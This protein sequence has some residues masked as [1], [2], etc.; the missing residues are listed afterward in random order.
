MKGKLNKQD[1]IFFVLVFVFLFYIQIASGFSII[2]DN[3]SVGSSS[4]GILGGQSENL[5]YSLRYSSLYSQLVGEAFNSN[6]T[7]KSGFL[8][9]VS[10]NVTTQNITNNV[11]V[12]SKQPSVTQSVSSGSSGI[13]ATTCNYEWVCSDWYPVPCPKEEIQKRVC[14]NRGTCNGSEGMP[15]LNRSCVSSNLPLN[16]P[17]F[18]IFISTLPPYKS[19]LSGDEVKFNIKLINKRDTPSLDVTF[20]YWIV[21]KNNKL[22]IERQ[23]TRAIKHDDEFNIGFAL[24]RNLEPGLYKT[25]V[26]IKY[27]SNKTALAQ[28]SFEVINGKYGFLTKIILFVLLIILVLSLM[29]R[30]FIKIV[31]KRRRYKS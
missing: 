24:P 18:D 23:D 9:V 27:D 15:E 3:Y 17:L 14:V 28:D 2:S 22:I 11:T 1:F 25:F 4:Q 29:M 10:I 16:K 6:Y 7:A 12:P 19:I 21:G 26:E 20:R 30:I 31:G 8:S 13:L 5:N